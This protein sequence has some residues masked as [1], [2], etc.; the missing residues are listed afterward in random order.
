MF[1]LIRACSSFSISIGEVSKDTRWRKKIFLV[2]SFGLL[3]V[4]VEFADIRPASACRHV[5]LSAELNRLGSSSTARTSRGV[6]SWSTVFLNHIRSATRGPD[7]VAQLRTQ[8]DRGAED[9]KL[10]G[11]LGKVEIDDEDEEGG[12][13]YNS[14]FSLMHTLLSHTCLPQVWYALRSRGRL[15]RARSNRAGGNTA[16]ALR[17]RG[18]YA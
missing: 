18:I 2:A 17:S 10:R 14:K 6:L 7:R 5:C 15:G 4:M 3:V 12:G 13:P 11:H 1:L 9:C 8:G 16:R